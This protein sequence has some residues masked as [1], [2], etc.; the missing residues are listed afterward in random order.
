MFFY[1]FNSNLIHF[2]RYFYLIKI[3]KFEIEIKILENL[4]KKDFICFDIG[5][6]HGSYARLLTKYS[7]QVYAFEAE[8]ENFRYLKEVM[9]Q[10]NLKIYNLAISNKNSTSILYIPK[11]KDKKNSAMSSL[12]K[13]Y[14]KNLKNSIKFISQKVKSVTLDNF[15]RKNNINKVDFIKIDV[16][17]HE[18]P[19]LKNSKLI[20]SKYKPIF[21]IEILKDGKKKYRKVFQFMKRYN[22]SS[23]YLSRKTIKFVKCSHYDVEKFQSNK[24]KL[25]KDNNFFDQN[26]I[27]NFFFF[28]DEKKIKNT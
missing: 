10:K 8:K 24:N 1:K 11:F 12:N 6:C 22:Y 13:G 14:K 15:V 18:L 7:N 17:G 4:I 3:N 9:R 2:L 16:E 27:Q 21:M 28:P 23:F 26:F 25:M 19:V 20:L 5:C